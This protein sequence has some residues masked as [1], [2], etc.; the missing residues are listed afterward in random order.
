MLLGTLERH[1]LCNCRYLKEI[2]PRRFVREHMFDFKV[3]GASIK[4]MSLAR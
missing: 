2:E 3:S 1:E 4:G